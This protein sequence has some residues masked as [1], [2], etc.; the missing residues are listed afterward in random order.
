MAIRPDP[1]DH[2]RYWD[3][4]VNVV[5][6][7][8]FAHRFVGGRK[9]IDPSCLNCYAVT[10]AAGL[11][12]AND[13]ERYRGTTERKGERDTWTIPAHLT[14]LEDGHRYW[15]DLL[16]RKFPHPLLGEGKPGII[17]LDSMS[18]LFHPGH[19]PEVI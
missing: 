2:L 9:L 15:T 7:C 1:L 10:Y 18:D 14:V 3:G 5:F 6:G 12:R 13:L 16:S 17:W 11:H 8:E 4:T 19:P